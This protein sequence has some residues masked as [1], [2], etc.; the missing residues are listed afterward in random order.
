MVR[1][2]WVGEAVG[3]QSEAA[4][5]HESVE[6]QGADGGRQGVVLP[7][8]EDVAEV[9]VGDD[10]GAEVR[11]RRLGVRIPSG[12]PEFVQVT[13]PVTDLRWPVTMIDPHTF[14]LTRGLSF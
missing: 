14:P 11:I 12:A 3:E 10:G 8:G 2:A 4:D 1:V 5:D 7:G 9:A 6:H 13:N